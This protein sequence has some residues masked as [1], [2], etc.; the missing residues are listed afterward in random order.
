MVKVDLWPDTQ[1]N[2]RLQ[3]RTCPAYVWCNP[4]STIF[5]CELRPL[6]IAIWKIQTTPHSFFYKSLPGN[7]CLKGFPDAIYCVDPRLVFL[8]QHRFKTTTLVAR[9]LNR[10]CTIDRILKS[11]IYPSFG[12]ADSTSFW[13]GFRSIETFEN[14]V[15]DWTRPKQISLRLL[16]SGPGRVGEALARASL[17]EVYLGALHESCKR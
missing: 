4:V 11:F 1:K 14:Q 12:W 16:P 15:R 9:Y 17:S 7:G 5:L 6:H 10:Q 2:N 3:S 13:R 8:D